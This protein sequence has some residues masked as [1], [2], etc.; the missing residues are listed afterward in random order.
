[1]PAPKK[2]KKR[3]PKKQQ[4]EEEA[5]RRPGMFAGGVEGVPDA[6]ASAARKLANGVIS[7]DEYNQIAK[8]LRMASDVMNDDDACEREKTL[9][10]R[11]STRPMTV[12]TQPSKESMSLPQ[13]QPSAPEYNHLQFQLPVEVSNA[14]LY[15]IPVSSPSPDKAAADYLR[16]H[17][18]SREG[19]GVDY[20][21]YPVQRNTAVSKKHWSRGSSPKLPVNLRVSAAAQRMTEFADIYWPADGDD[22]DVEEAY[23]AVNK[24]ELPPPVSSRAP[25][26]I[27]KGAAAEQERS[28][29]G[30]LQTHTLP[31]NTKL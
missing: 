29:L 19:G 23:E 16:P 22:G 28:A 7:Q 18:A 1:M 4:A 31:A 26:S 9:K 21:E 13:M 11:P 12:E 17:S 14:L 15:E 5:G 10:I 6:A 8:V 3:L 24:Q 20:R 30:Q 27:L 2:K 25:T